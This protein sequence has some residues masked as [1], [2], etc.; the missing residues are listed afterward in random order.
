[1]GR[2]RTARSRKASEMSDMASVGSMTQSETHV[3]AVLTMGDLPFSVFIRKTAL[4]NLCGCNNCGTAGVQATK[5]GRTGEYPLDNVGYLT[6]S[7]AAMKSRAA[8]ISANNIANANTE[9][10]RA[11]RNL[12]ETYMANTGT[13]DDLAPMAYAM[14]RGTYNDLR[15]GSMIQT[16]NPST[17]PSRATPSSGSSVRTACLRSAG[18]AASPS[19]PKATS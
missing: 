7:T 3:I 10:F 19:T 6:L 18:P 17:S 16:G 14:D 15:E 13:H 11:S 4:R 12:F 2:S 5:T 9:G 8:D 1:M